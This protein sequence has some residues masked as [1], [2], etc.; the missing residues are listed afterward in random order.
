[1]IRQVNVCFLSLTFQ[2]IESGVAIRDSPIEVGREDEAKDSAEN[3]DLFSNCG[4]SVVEGESAD[5]LQNDL[6]DDEEPNQ[7]RIFVFLTSYKEHKYHMGPRY[8]YYRYRG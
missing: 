1:M 3:F 5:F 6:D 7:V 2:L 4:S 8:P